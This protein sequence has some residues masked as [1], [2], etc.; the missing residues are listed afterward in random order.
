MSSTYE[1]RQNWKSDGEIFSGEIFKFLRGNRDEEI[2]SSPPY[3]YTR[4]LLFE[5]LHHQNI[6][7]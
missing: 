2:L 6:G 7:N 5:K 3:P 4:K 1:N